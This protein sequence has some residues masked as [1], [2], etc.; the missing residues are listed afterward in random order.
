MSL[1]QR[2]LSTELGT[3]HFMDI[4]SVSY[5]IGIYFSTISI[6]FNVQIKS[7]SVIKTNLNII[8]LM[9]FIYI[10]F[11]FTGTHYDLFV[12]YLAPATAY[13]I[14]YLTLQSTRRSQILLLSGNV[15]YDVKIHQQ[16]NFQ[17]EFGQWLTPI[18]GAL[19]SISALQ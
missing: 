10:F 2:K 9:D 6:I 7:P 17:V 11:L 14:L 8:H 12:Q 18:N 5:F 16:D 3:A 13:Y 15:V 1:K 4:V 19:L